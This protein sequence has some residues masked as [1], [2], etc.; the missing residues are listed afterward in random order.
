[1]KSITI[2]KNVEKSATAGETTEVL[3]CIESSGSSVLLKEKG[4]KHASI[5]VMEI[6][7]IQ[8]S[9]IKTFIIRKLPKHIYNNSI[10]QGNFL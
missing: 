4:K 1:M 6:S 3:K 10:F 2:E 8:Q 9:D 7:E 5:P